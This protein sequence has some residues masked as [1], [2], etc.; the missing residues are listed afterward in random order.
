MGVGSPE[1]KFQG[2]AKFK[3][4]LDGMWVVGRLDVKKTKTHPAFKG[5]FSLGTDGTQFISSNID[6]MGNAGLT[7]GALT[8]PSNIITIGEGTAMG[9][10][11]KMR[12]TMQKKSDKELYHKLEIDMGKGFQTVGEDTC[13][14]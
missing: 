2:I 6:N 13:K 1:L 14:K 12:E 5:A 9:A 11:A 8:D 4:D 10:K 3:R 7:F